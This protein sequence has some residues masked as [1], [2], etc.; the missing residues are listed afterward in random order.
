MSEAPMESS[1]LNDAM[2]MPKRP[3]EATQLYETIMPETL[4]DFDQLNVSMIPECPSKIS[5][6]STITTETVHLSYQPGEEPPSK[7][8][9]T[10]D[11]WC[12]SSR[13]LQKLTTDIAVI[14]VASI[15]KACERPDHIVRTKPLDTAN[16]VAYAVAGH[17]TAR[18]MPLSESD[19]I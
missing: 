19:P 9:R 17:A 16:L 3:I 18:Q 12:T 13:E 11:G 6:P 2:R 10:E 5:E 7:K 15:A 4:R 1:Q 8:R 14:T